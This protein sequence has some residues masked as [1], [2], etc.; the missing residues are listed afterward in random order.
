M[1]DFSFVKSKSFLSEILE[2]SYAYSE[3]YVNVHIYHIFTVLGWPIFFQSSPQDSGI[4]T[5]FWI[6][7]LKETIL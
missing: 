4:N 3:S 5:H 6:T 1:D 2:L 7:L